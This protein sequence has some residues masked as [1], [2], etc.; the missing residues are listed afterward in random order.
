MCVGL[1]KRISETSMSVHTS[2]WTDRILFEGLPLFF[3][4]TLYRFDHAILFIQTGP[5]SDTLPGSCSQISFAYAQNAD[6]S[7]QYRFATFVLS[8]SWPLYRT[9]FTSSTQSQREWVLN[10][11]FADFENAS[12]VEESNAPHPF[13][14]R[15]TSIK[16]FVLEAKVS[17]LIS[18]RNMQ[19]KKTTHNFKKSPHPSTATFWLRNGQGIREFSSTSLL[20][21]KCG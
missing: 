5:L 21:H 4:D 16:R 6:L 7:K 18:Y 20:R 15:P 13:G 3:G 9:P 1:N 19:G 17:P 10:C 11:S 2:T 14:A 12:A 8:S